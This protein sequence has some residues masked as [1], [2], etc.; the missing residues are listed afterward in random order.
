MEVHDGQISTLKNIRVYDAKTWKKR[1][2]NADFSEVP[3]E[4]ENNN[5]INWDECR[6]CFHDTRELIRKQRKETPTFGMNWQQQL[7]IDLRD[8]LSQLILDSV[9]NHMIFYTKEFSKARKNY[10]IFEQA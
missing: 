8:P 4:C 3:K 9:K 6:K 5:E 10:S 7:V 1:I 2:L